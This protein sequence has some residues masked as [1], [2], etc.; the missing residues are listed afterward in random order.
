MK[1]FDIIEGM[2]NKNEFRN[3][4][5][6][7]TSGFDKVAQEAKKESWADHLKKA[8]FL[9]G[10]ASGEKAEKTYY[11]LTETDRYKNMS[12][13][14]QKA[15]KS[16]YESWDNYDVK[17]P[18]EIGKMVE[19]AV[20]DPDYCFGIHRSYAIDGEKY[21]NDEILHSILTDGLINMGNASSGNIYKDP[22]LEKTVMVCNDML[23]ATIG[24]KT[25]YKG[26]TG[27]VLVKVP[28][29]YVDKNTGDI[30]PGM[31]N[32]VYNHNELGNSMI[33]PEFIMGFVQN[34]GE[35]STLEYKTRNEI[36]NNEKETP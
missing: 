23:N 3:I 7:Q 21:E 8:L 9:R 22:S 16:A 10:I 4:E 14:E 17:I 34:L 29:K 32:E 33:K 24:L 20:N 27:A 19:Y 1:F 36:L 2:E 13:K 28:T 26:S 31:E 35:G 30:K 15:W 5:A 6:E 11:K 25:S 18:M 12:K